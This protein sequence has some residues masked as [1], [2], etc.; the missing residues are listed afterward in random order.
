[1]LALRAAC[2]PTQYWN[3][4]SC[5]ARGDATAR[6]A[7]GK[8]ALDEQNV[9]AAK[10]AF[11]AAERG[12]PL[13]HAS[14]ILLWE[15]RGIAAAYLRDE[16]SATRAF[17][18]LLALHPEHFLSYRLKPEVTLVFEKVRTGVIGNLPALDIV[19]PSG[20]R[21]GEPIPLDVRVIADPKQFLDRATIF[22]RGRGETGW[23]A[24]DL[25]LAGRREARVVLPAVEAA[26]PTS[27]ELY[28]RGYDRSGNEVLAWADPARPRELPLRYDPPKSWYQKWPT[29]AI[30]VPAL[31]AVTGVIVYAVVVKP[32]R[33]DG[34]VVSN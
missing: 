4:S 12:G 15:Q 13:D 26:K 27:L 23:R 1:M 29:Y 28:A 21:V 33:V 22:V 25:A 31:I 10:L 7:E 16:P 14:N 32:D 3:G 19:W 5:V 11:D 17:D 18:M 8:A 2:E 6:L 9:D 30:G 20:H 24:A 34:G